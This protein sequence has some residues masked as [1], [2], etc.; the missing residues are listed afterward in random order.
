MQKL[1]P[2]R[3]SSHLHNFSASANKGLPFQASSPKNLAGPSGPAF[4][5]AVAQ[6]ALP[7]DDEML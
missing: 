3:R 7:G 5:S 1:H 4:F 6:K 2:M